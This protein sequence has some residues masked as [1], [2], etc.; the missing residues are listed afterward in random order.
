MTTCWC[1]CTGARAGAGCPPSTGCTS[2]TNLL[3]GDDYVLVYLHGSAGRRRLPTFHWLHE[4]YKLIDRRCVRG[5]VGGSGGLE[6]LV[7]DDYVLVYLH[8][9]AG[10]RRLP[11]FHWLHECYKLI[12]RRGGEGGSGGLERLVTD[13]YVLVYLHGSAGRR[14]LPTFHWLHERYKLIDR[15]AGR[16]RLPTFHHW[17][18][19]CYKPIDRRWSEG[20]WGRGLERLVTDDYVLVYASGARAGG[21]LPTFHWLHECYKPLTGDDYVLVHPHR[22]RRRAGC[23]PSTGCTSA[24]KLIGQAVSEGEWGSGLRAGNRYPHGSAGRRRLPTF[25]WLHECYKLIDRR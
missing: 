18:H 9:S 3:T 15:R 20:E 2:A 25:H 5:G 16:R 24:A 23:P 21:R 7:T 13:D 22:A 17:L 11:T 10:R 4:C 12:D 1:T 8:G 19:E 6:R 14:R